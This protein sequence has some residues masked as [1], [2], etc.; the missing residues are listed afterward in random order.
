MER[1][2]DEITNYFLERQMS[3]F[4]EEFNN[5]VKVPKRRYYGIIDVGRIF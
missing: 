1:R 2:L 3:G 5:R 4:V